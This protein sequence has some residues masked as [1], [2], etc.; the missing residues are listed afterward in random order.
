[1]RQLAALLLI[2]TT[3]AC[4]GASSQKSSIAALSEAVYKL[5]PRPKK[6]A[7]AIIGFVPLGK[8]EVSSD[9]FS[10]YLVEEL[11]MKLVSDGRVTVAERAQLEK[12]VNELKLQSSGMVSDASA[13]QLGQ[14]LGVDAV[15]I[16]SYL[17][18][19]KQVKVNQRLVGTESGEVLAAST[20]MF[21]KTKTIRK[22]LAKPRPARKPR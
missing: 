12:V 6:L 10:N 20:A 22:L 13:K 8:S 9:P 2:V 7:I 21:E 3:S 15:V 1:M 19:G 4:G 17:D 18:E 11:T 14:M 5:P 16:G